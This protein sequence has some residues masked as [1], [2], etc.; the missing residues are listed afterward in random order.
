MRT[1]AGIVTTTDFASFTATSMRPPS[2]STPQW[3]TPAVPPTSLVSWIE[4]QS[5]DVS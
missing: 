1:P 3:A 2:Q 4:P 5:P